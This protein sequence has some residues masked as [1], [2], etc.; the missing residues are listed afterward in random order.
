MAANTLARVNKENEIE[1]FKETRKTKIAEDGFAK[2]DERDK[3]AVAQAKKNAE[4]ALKLQVELEKRKAEAVANI[5]KENINQEIKLNELIVESDKSTLDE[6]LLAADKVRKAKAALLSIEYSEAIAAEIKVEDG[7]RVIVEKTAD[8]KLLAETKYQNS[9]TD[10]LAETLK[11]QE[12]LR[13]ADAERQKEAF[14]KLKKQ[15]GEGADNFGENEKNITAIRRNKKLL[16]LDADF[17]AGRIKNVEEY[18]KKKQAIIEAGDKKEIEAAL[19]VAYQKLEIAIL[20]GDDTKAIEKDITALNLQ[21]MDL[22]VD[23]AKT[24][25]EKKLEI[26]KGLAEKKKELLSAGKDLLISIVDGQFERQKNQIQELIQLNE[27]Q[28]NAEIERV[29]QGTASEKEKADKIALIN[30][31]AQQKKEALEKRQRQIELQK[32]EFDQLVSIA[33]VVANTAKA[34]TKDLAGNKALIPIDIAIGAAQIAAILA[35]PLPKFKDGLFDDYEGWAITGDGG[36][37]EVIKRK[38]GGIEVTPAT[39]TLTWINKGDR[40]DPDA[41]SFFKSM[42]MGAISNAARI[43]SDTTQEENYAKHMVNALESGLKA[44]ANKIVAA[45]DGIPKVQMGA[46]KGGLEALWKYGANTVKYINENTNWD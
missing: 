8:E 16:Q 45:L 31:E 41:D 14:A 46:T 15:L 27:D 22:E 37:S 33:E 44:N 29:L 1:L 32:A 28:K 10:L 34:V 17:L 39:D 24:T 7:K 18:E 3:K 43:A 23:K 12:E 5:V 4:E 6:K 25:A 21:L 38:A 36:R 40:I 20:F 11:K 42:Q 35:R 26:E 2:Q 13:K 9:S 30:A 19:E